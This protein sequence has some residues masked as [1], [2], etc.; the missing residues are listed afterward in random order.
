[1][2]RVCLLT[3]IA[4]LIC[5]VGVAQP[6]TKAERKALI[7]QS[8]VQRSSGS[9]TYM[10]QTFNDTYTDLTGT[11]SLNN[12]EIWD[13]PDYII[14]VPFPFYVNGNEVVVLA[15]A[16]TGALLLSPTGNPDYFELII[17]F[18]ADLM[19]RGALLGL[20]SESP[21][22]YRVD[23]A[24]GSRILKVEWNNAGSYDEM[25]FA[26]TMDMYINFQMWLYEGIDMIE[27]RFGPSSITDGDLFYS[28]E[29]GALIGLVS[30]DVA[31]LEL[32]NEH[33][34]V[35]D[36][37]NPMLSIIDDYING[38]PPEGTV[39]RLYLTLPL[40]LEVTGVNGTCG[41]PN[42][43]ATASVSGGAPPYTYDWS[44][45]GATQTITDLDAGIYTVTVTDSDGA[46]ASGSVEILNVDPLFANASATDETAPGANDGTATAD[47]FGGTPPYT[48][49]WDNGSTD[50]V[51]TDLAPGDYTVTVTD[52]EGC[53]DSETVTVFAAPDCPEIGVVVEIVDLACFDICDGSVEVLEVI[54]GAPPVSFAWSTGGIDTFISDL[55]AGSYTVT[56]T[57]AEGCTA[58]ATFDVS[59][60]PQLHANAGSTNETQ[61]DANDGTAWSAPTGGVEPYTY[62]WSTGSLDSLITDLA[63]GDYTVTVTDANGCTAE[64]TVTVEAAGC[65]LT[66][67]ATIT[68]LTCFESCD[69]SIELA[70]SGGAPPYMIEWYDGTGDETL[71]DLC[72]GD[73]GVTVTDDE[74]CVYE[75]TFTVTEPDELLANAGSTHETDVDA[76]DG[77][78]WALPTGGT[79]PYTYAWN[80]GETEYLITNL[81]P[82]DYTVTVTDAAGCTVEATVTVLSY[83][84]TLLVLTAII[85]DLNCFDICDGSIEVEVDGATPPLTYA[86]SNGGDEATITDLCA[87]SYSVTVTD[88]NSCQITGEFDVTAPE[89]LLPNAGSSDESAPDAQDGSAWAAPSGGVPPY[90]YT[91]STGETDSLIVV[92]APG[93]Y[94]VT[95]TDDAGCTAEETVT[96]NAYQC[97]LD[98]TATFILISCADTCDGGIAVLAIGLVGPITYLWSNGVT[99]PFATGLCA[100][101]NSVTVTDVGQGCSVE[102]SYT[103]E[104]PEALV[105]EIA[106]LIHI[107]DS[108]EAS[109]TINVTGGTPPYAFA[110]TGPDGFES[111]AQDIA[112]I[113]AG[114]YTLEVTDANGCIASL[115]DVEVIDETVNT[116]DPEKLDV[117]VF[118]NPAN[119]FVRLLVRDVHTF[120]IELKSVDGRMIGMWKNENTLDLRPFA[121]GVYILQL[122]SGDRSAVFRIVVAR[123]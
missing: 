57:D 67:D 53:V 55:C 33:F 21:L 109:V 19:D 119:T 41:E 39:Y 6:G 24:P 15:F 102:A 22:S 74:G 56:V 17:P 2:M 37:G 38:T 82:G 111:D 68:S 13:D 4:G 112:G 105:V 89:Q 98:L 113:D 3:V 45:G 81:A 8:Q 121:E 75:A 14:P 47:P 20:S 117:L 123:E 61:Q 59:S 116:S 72:A 30:L 42:G 107:T 70:I 104:E 5:A 65:T 66:A 95:V 97:V 34:L 90:T 79:E 1:M 76:E 54:G 40:E 9:F 52:A 28:G 49:A 108:T 11:T 44:N 16:G 114:F 99:L 118:P 26:G 18:E 86:W 73:Y 106:E 29:S 60:P 58:E 100:G 96:V 32:Y 64:E 122:V 50:P 63:P 46:S 71:S 87:G 27:Y 62:A 78:A 91:W 31:L 110:W 36:A 88:D 94:T 92:L 25:E 115:D 103:L 93:D 101:V 69:G 83:E 77:T 80:T 51:I 84:C 85:V 10:L 120:D 48:Y 7:P 12:G 35:G 43:S 23:G